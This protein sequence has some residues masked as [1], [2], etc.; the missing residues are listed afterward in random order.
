[1][2][3]LE[4]GTS[5]WLISILSEILEP[6]KI[7]GTYKNNWNLSFRKGFVKIKKIINIKYMKN[8]KVKN[9]YEK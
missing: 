7:M 9:I 2:N 3:L 8:K 5:F 1:M 4:I 6:I